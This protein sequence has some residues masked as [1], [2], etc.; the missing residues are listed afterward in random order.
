MDLIIHHY[1]GQ[2]AVRVLSEGERYIRLQVDKSDAILP[3][4]CRYNLPGW[5]EGAIEAAGGRPQVRKVR[6]THDGHA[7]CEYDVRWEM[8]PQSAP[9]SVKAS[10]GNG[11]RYEDLPMPDS[12]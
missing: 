4:M 12:R 1:W 7:C 2:M 5:M 3:E 10:S 8:A 11:R 6:C 9:S